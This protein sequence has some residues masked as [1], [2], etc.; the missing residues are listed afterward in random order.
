MHHSNYISQNDN[1]IHVVFSYLNVRDLS[2]L[3]NVSKSFNK[4]TNG[5]NHYWHNACFKYF[6]SDNDGYRYKLKIIY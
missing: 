6:C 2:I 1:L 3:K 4:T 5:F